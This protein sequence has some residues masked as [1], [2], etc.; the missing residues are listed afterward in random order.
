ME[1]IK[2]ALTKV[3]DD[4]VDIVCNIEELKGKNS[5][6]NSE[7]ELC[8][9]PPNTSNEDP[10]AIHT[11]DIEI[12]APPPTTADDNL[13]E[14]ATSIDHFVGIEVD[15]TETESNSQEK[16]LNYQSLTIQL[17]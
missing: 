8:S 15:S 7:I 10:D 13:D 11:V 14:S 12:H 4:I 6:K 5:D 2:S 17:D 3:Q 9:P 1:E 16:T